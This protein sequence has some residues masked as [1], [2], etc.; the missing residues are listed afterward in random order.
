MD[1]PPDECR[2][3]LRFRLNDASGV[4]RFVEFEIVDTPACRDLETTLRDY[5][6]GRPLAEVD[7]EYLQELRCAGRCECIHTVIGEV[8]KHQALFLQDRRKK[9]A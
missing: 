1:V 5:L 2:D 6:V 8:Q 4:L 7:L 3:R 9:P